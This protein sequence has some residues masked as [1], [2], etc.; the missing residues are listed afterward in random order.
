MTA[1]VADNSRIL[2]S[3]GGDR[4]A[5]APH[6]EQMRD[7]FRC[8][9][10]FVGLETVVTVKKP[11]AKSLLEGVQAIADGGLGNVRNQRLRVAKSF[12]CPSAKAQAFYRE[13]KH[14]KRIEPCWFANIQ[15]LIL[16]NNTGNIN[17]YCRYFQFR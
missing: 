17:L 15:R 12:G 6:A 14:Q 1:H 16:F 10:N 8:Q 4:H 9:N 3:F 7:N 11:A 13:L 5:F 2:K